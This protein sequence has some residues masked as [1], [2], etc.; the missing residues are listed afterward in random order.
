MPKLFTTTS[1][2]VPAMQSKFLIESMLSPLPRNYL[3]GNF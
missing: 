1:A 2:A 3:S